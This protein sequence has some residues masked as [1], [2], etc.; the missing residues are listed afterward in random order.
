MKNI[1]KALAGPILDNPDVGYG[2]HMRFE[3]L[4]DFD[5]RDTVFIHASASAT[6][7]EFILELHNNGYVTPKH[8]LFISSSNSIDDIE[9]FSRFDLSKPL[10]AYPAYFKLD[11]P[12]K[13]YAIDS[14]NVA[15]AYVILDTVGLN[16]NIENLVDYNPETKNKFQRAPSLTPW[17]MKPRNQITTVRRN[18]RFYLV[19]N[20]GDIRNSPVM[21]NA[22]EDVLQSLESMLGSL[23]STPD[24]STYFDADSSHDNLFTAAS[25]GDIETLERLIGGGQYDFE[26]VDEYNRTILFHAARHNQLET[27]V[28]ILED[29]GGRE[30]IDYVDI[31]GNNVIGYV[32]KEG[33]MVGEGTTESAAYGSVL[34]YL[35]DRGVRFF[36]AAGINRDVLST[37]NLQLLIHLM[38]FDEVISAT[39][40][41]QFAL[42]RHCM[43]LRSDAT[44]ND[45][46]FLSGESTTRSFIETLLTE[47][48]ADE[49]NFIVDGMTPLVT[50]IERENYTIA[51]L[52][53]SKG[54][55]TDF[56]DGQGRLP[57]DVLPDDVEIDGILRSPPAD[58]MSRIA[59]SIRNR[60]VI[61]FGMLIQE[62]H[63]FTVIKYAGVTTTVINVLCAYEGDDM[64]MML[65]V[66]LSWYSNTASGLQNSTAMIA[67]PLYTAVVNQN[68]AAV[69]RL[70]IAGANPRMITGVMTQTP[71]QR[72]IH[73]TFWPIA[74]AIVQNTVFEA[75]ELAD[76][77]IHLLLN[78]DKRDVVREDVLS[79]FDVCYNVN[80]AIVNVPIT[81]TPDIICTI[82]DL[83]RGF[84]DASLNKY[85]SVKDESRNTP[86]DLI[87]LEYAVV[88]SDM[89]MFNDILR[90]SR[91]GL[92][93]PDFSSVFR[94]RTLRRISANHPIKAA[95]R[96]L[97]GV[98][99]KRLVEAGVGSLE[100]N[101]ENLFL[102]MVS[103][104]AIE[105]I[106][107]VLSKSPLEVPGRVLVEAFK[108]DLTVQ[109]RNLLI[110]EIARRTNML[111]KD[112]P[113]SEIQQVI[114]PV[115]L[116][117]TGSGLPRMADVACQSN[118][119]D[120][121]KY[122]SS[123]P[124]LVVTRDTVSALRDMVPEWLKDE[125]SLAFDRTIP[126]DLGWRK[127]M[128]Q[129]LNVNPLSLRKSIR[130]TGTIESR[131]SRRRTPLM[132]AIDNSNPVAFF[133]LL[134]E[135]ANY[136]SAIRSVDGLTVLMH[137]VSSNLLPEFMKHILHQNE[138][139]TLI[140]FVDV[141]GRTVLE[142]NMNAAMKRELM[143]HIPMIENP[144]PELR[145]FAERRAVVE[146][147]GLDERVVNPYL[148]S[149]EVLDEDDFI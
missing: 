47:M 29:M 124:D 52:L 54:A 66:L 53:I 65:D 102:S 42:H 14:M 6:V 109:T 145:D 139:T 15:N 24:T 149:T 57:A 97:N 121:L 26:T 122:I 107:Y 115:I 112:H 35:V 126:V 103:S 70:L 104:R 68:M 136:S 48:T 25:S 91:E 74:K 45:D 110:A 8:S 43:A 99:Y 4:F 78:L 11:E 76:I 148:V 16:N 144:T 28:W 51:R 92:K 58:T 20:D 79:F 72:A 62:V 113:L 38:R 116:M 44:E 98:Y 64:E 73:E 133:A 37:T 130:Q 143:S 77:C 27:M 32:V 31:E 93:I 123:L 87:A 140:Q 88:N 49:L 101:G 108:M 17:N 30:L 83:L 146:R 85:R 55:R 81:V 69:K 134:S 59:T 111:R 46:E 131:D 40:R 135:G 80:P 71:L 1:G 96:H 90:M 7:S 142:Y 5:D 12:N 129:N 95:A 63:P 3:L 75:A 10:S 82:S 106:Q 94:D 119:V 9:P 21:E 36:P 100:Y 60:D 125:V 50:A 23:N 84:T 33:I 18:G 41:K 147:L 117:F 34:E 89:A 114:D 56:A 120:V 2:A 86:Y 22:D 132:V 141:N 128:L 67:T 13:I 61:E 137:F 39:D 138:I 127:T 105:N 19:E 118:R